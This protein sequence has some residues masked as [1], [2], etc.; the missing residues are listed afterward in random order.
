MERRVRGRGVS[1]LIPQTITLLHRARFKGSRARAASA[2]SA[3]RLAA[4]DGLPQI[5]CVFIFASFA[6]FR[7]HLRPESRCPIIVAVLVLRS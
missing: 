6:P 4:R 1:S 3:P 5:I 7:G 2:V